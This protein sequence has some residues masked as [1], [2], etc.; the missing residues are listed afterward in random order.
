M[1]RQPATKA[2]ALALSLVV[3]ALNNFGNL[4]LAYG[5]RQL[6]NT[7]GTNP[8]DYIR[9]MF[10]PLVALGIALLIGW[11][12]T[13]MTLL[14]WADLSFVLPVTATGY[15]LNMVLSQTYLHETVGARS[16]AGAVLITAGAALAG[17]AAPKEG[18]PDGPRG[19]AR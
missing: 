6:P 12:L 7:V 13:R 16:W 1:R 14:S 19:G 4:I 17:S 10:H 5:M 8:L 18:L 9:A 11:M 2:R 3:I 15:V